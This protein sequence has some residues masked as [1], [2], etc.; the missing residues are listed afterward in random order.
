[1]ATTPDGILPINGQ[2]IK[3]KATALF[4]PNTANDHERVKQTVVERM[5]EV[6]VNDAATAGTAVTETV[7]A[8]FPFASAGVKVLGCT[9]A[10]PIAVTANDTSYATVTLASRDSAGANA[11]TIGSQT[12][13]ITGGTGNITAFKPYSL[14]LTAANVIVPQGGCLTIAVAKASSGVAL[15][16]A[17]S[18]VNVTV[19]YEEL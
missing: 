4:S 2:E 7:V 13:K 8:T 6:Q 3:N 12:T 15:T 10:T 11:L 9:F 5:V 18:T 19:F 14:T 17:T 16:A 1:M